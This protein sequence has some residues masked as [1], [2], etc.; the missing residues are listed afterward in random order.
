MRAHRGLLAAIAAIALVAGLDAPAGRS[1]QATPRRLPR[2]PHP[3]LGCRCTRRRSTRVR[4]TA[5]PTRATR[6]SR[7]SKIDGGV[8]IVLVLYPLAAQG[9][10]E[11]GHRPRGVDQHRGRHGHRPGQAAEGAPASRS[12]RTTTVPTAC[13]PTWTRSSAANP[14]LLKLEVIGQTY[15]TD[16]EGDGPDTPRDIVALKLTV[17]AN[18][19]PDNSRPGGAL[20]RDAAR[21]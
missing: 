4:R 21:P 6:S 12:G 11:A 16:P 17:D 1:E 3:R 15:G 7:P 10:R 20:Q 14:D 13:A 8:H 19:V 18:T 5:W 9:D 2:R